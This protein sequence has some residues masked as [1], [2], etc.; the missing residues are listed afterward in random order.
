MVSGK[1]RIRHSF[2]SDTLVLNERTEIWLKEDGTPI[3][4]HPVAVMGA[5]EVHGGKITYWRDYWDAAP[6]VAIADGSVTAGA[7]G[8]VA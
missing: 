1:A 8:H 7:N 4:D 5:F 6:V 2:A 3:I